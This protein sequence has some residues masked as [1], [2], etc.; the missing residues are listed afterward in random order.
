MV[1]VDSVIWTS[2]GGDVD[3]SEGI[4]KLTQSILR[5]YG[6]GGLILFNLILSDYL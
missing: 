6:R 2:R 3:G 1:V 5:E 4:L